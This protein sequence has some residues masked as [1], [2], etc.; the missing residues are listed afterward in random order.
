MLSQLNEVNTNPFQQVVLYYIS[1]CVVRDVMHD[2]ECTLCAQALTTTGV[3]SSLNDH[4]SYSK[5]LSFSHSYSFIAH[6]NK[7]GLIMPSSGVVKVVETCEQAFR[8]CV[9]GENSTAI[10]A[11]QCINVLMLKCSFA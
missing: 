11:K 6:K 3:V 7:E 8:A 9:C 2:I 5:S 1:G 4:L 10:T